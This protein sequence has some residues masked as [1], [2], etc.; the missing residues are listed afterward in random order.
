MS[1][2]FFVVG[3]LFCVLSYRI[4]GQVPDA[5]KYQ[6]VVRDGEGAVVKSSLVGLKINILQGAINGTILYTE[7]HSIT[8]NSFGLVGIDIGKG[9]VVAG[10]FAMIPWANGPYFIEVSLDVEG[11]T[12]YTLMGTSQLLSVPYALHAKTADS[13]LSKPQ[14]GI[15]EI[16]Q[17]GSNA[18]NLSLSNLGNITIGTAVPEPSAAVTINSNSQGILLPRMT[19]AERDAILKPA[20]GL[21]LF[22][23]SSGKLNYRSSNL[24][25]E[26]SGTCIPQ[27]SVANAGPDQIDVTGTTTTLA[28][29]G[30]IVGNGFWTIVSGSGGVL[31]DS[32]IY[33]TTFRGLPGV[34][35]ALQWTISTECGSTNDKVT[36]RFASINHHIGDSYAGGV[37]FYLDESGGGLVLYNQLISFALWGCIG[38]DVSG[39][40]TGI[41]TGKLNN[42]VT[43][44]SQCTVWPISVAKEFVANGFDDWFLPSRDELQLLYTTLDAIGMVNFMKNDLYKSFWSSSQD[45]ANKAWR[46][47]INNGTMES[48]PK[49]TDSRYVVIRSFQ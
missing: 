48:V 5:F 3:L 43:V 45:D 18:E 1:K 13:L 38:I 4:H 8:T 32:S 12:N 49:T 40:S 11:G 47:N 22:N 39:T 30:T 7:T 19:T 33:N 2:I 14:I 20:N 25:F 6:A 42:N 16:L 41:G 10:N 27:P 44:P 35:Y 15:S 29:N 24:W 46:L 37:I 31:T 17:N 36:V 28:A 34:N 23:V 9:A 26:V 21:M